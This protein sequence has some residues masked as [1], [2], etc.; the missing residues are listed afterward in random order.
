MYDRYAGAKLILMFAVTASGVRLPLLVVTPTPLPVRERRYWQLWAERNHNSW[1]YFRVIPSAAAPSSTSTVLWLEA[2]ASKE[3]QAYTDRQAWVRDQWR[4][5]GGAH[6]TIVGDQLP[7][8]KTKAALRTMERYCLEH[9]FTAKYFG[10]YQSPLDNGFNADFRRRHHE[11]VR[12]GKTSAVGCV[13]IAYFSVPDKLIYNAFHAAGWHDQHCVS[14]NEATGDLVVVEGAKRSPAKIV[15]SFEQIGYIGS[16][17]TTTEQRAAIDAYEQW[18][19]TS[20]RDAAIGT[21]HHVI[22]KLED[23]LDGGKNNAYGRS[24]GNLY[25][26]SYVGN[27]YRPH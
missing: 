26:K 25:G 19:A 11:L 17:R 24:L 12:Q 18:C 8:H 10:R 3:E 6:V 7:G 27:V 21:R 1:V 14:V 22:Y 2:M 23:D 13:V 9:L 5:A 20:F 4:P 16:K 15:K